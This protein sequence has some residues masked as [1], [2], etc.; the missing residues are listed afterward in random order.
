MW[1][2]ERVNNAL[3]GVWSPVNAAQTFCKVHGKDSQGIAVVRKLTVRLLDPKEAVYQD[4]KVY[5]A[6]LALEAT[7]RPKA[8]HSSYSGRSAGSREQMP[9][10]EEE[11]PESHS[12]ELS[13]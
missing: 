5:V 8:T 4:S 9:V 11:P 12:T 3:G 7:R 1:L 13:Q 2:N 10:L 6:V